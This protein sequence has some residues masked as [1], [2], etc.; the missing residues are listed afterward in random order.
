M[1]PRAIAP[2][3]L[4]GFT[5]WRLRAFACPLPVLLSRLTPRQ[6]SAGAGA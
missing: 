6:G 4:T 1:T 3:N 5:V 2:L